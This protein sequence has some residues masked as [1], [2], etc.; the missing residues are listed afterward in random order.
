MSER[1]PFPQKWDMLEELTSVLN[2][3]ADVNCELAV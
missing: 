3:V 2:F 1:C